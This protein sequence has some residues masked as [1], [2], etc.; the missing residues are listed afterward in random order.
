MKINTFFRCD[1]PEIQKLF[2]TEDDPIKTMEKM[3]EL[4]N[5]QQYAMFYYIILPKQF[6]II[7][8]KNKDILYFL[9]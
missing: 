7:K 6:F 3:R 8:K 1:D 2:G 9:I 4:K 5:Q